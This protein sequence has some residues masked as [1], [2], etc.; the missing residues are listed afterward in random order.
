MTIKQIIADALERLDEPPTPF[1]YT[2]ELTEDNWFMSRDPYGIR[3][4]MLH[5]IYWEP[6]VHDFA[7]LTPYRSQWEHDIS[8]WGFFDSDFGWFEYSLNR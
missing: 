1:Q 7:K 2:M 5:R 3:V 8:C 4:E 6:D